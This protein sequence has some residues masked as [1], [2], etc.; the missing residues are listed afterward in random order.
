MTGIDIEVLWYSS[1][2]RG[3]SRQNCTYTY[4]MNQITAIVTCLGSLLLYRLSSY[5]GKEW[6]MG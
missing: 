1:V 4:R 3:C 6:T 2:G 5:G